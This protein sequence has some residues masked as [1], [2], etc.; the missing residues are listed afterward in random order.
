MDKKLKLPIDDKNV[1]SDWIGDF[2]YQ[3]CG[4]DYLRYEEKNNDV[5]IMK[6][7]SSVFEAKTDMYNIN[8]RPIYLANFNEWKDFIEALKEY[9]FD[10]ATTFDE[11]INV[12]LIFDSEKA[13]IYYT[14]K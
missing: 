1:S 6:Y 7:N 14:Q 11:D 8:I 13:T 3:Y 4:F 2:A 12:Y 10:A 5:Y 9:L